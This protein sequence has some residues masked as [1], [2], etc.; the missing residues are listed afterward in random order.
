MWAHGALPYLYDGST[1]VYICGDA[2]GP[3]DAQIWGDNLMNCSQLWNDMGDALPDTGMSCWG[4]YG[5]WD[6]NE[7]GVRSMH[8]GGA[9]TCFADGSVHWISDYI[10]ASPS[11]PWALSVWD[12]LMLSADGIPV[13]ESQF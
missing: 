1:L 2:Y 6:S 7:Q 11:L 9:N 13:D 5:P 3:N 8:A 10:Q 4:R 12:R